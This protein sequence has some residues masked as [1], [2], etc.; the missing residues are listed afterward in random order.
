MKIKCEFHF[1]SFQFPSS[2][3]AHSDSKVLYERTSPFLSF[4]SLQA[5]RHIQTNTGNTGGNTGGNSFNSLQAGR[6][7][8]TGGPG[9][10]GW[11]QIY[12]FQFPSSGKAHSDLCLVSLLFRVP[13]SIPFKREG[14]FRPATLTRSEKTTKFQFPSS[15]KAHSDSSAAHR[16]PGFCFNSLQ[17]GRHIQTQAR[18]KMANFSNSFNSLQAGRHIQTHVQD[19]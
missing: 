5:G 8:Q 1:N 13:V 9:V 12:L 11:C 14:T 16:T 3:K 19:T 2:G 15:G 10:T 7:I 4:N 6:H 17:A 18:N